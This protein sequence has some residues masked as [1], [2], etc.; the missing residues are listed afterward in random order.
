MYTEFLTGGIDSV[1]PANIYSS[2][3]TDS[4]K[5]CAEIND[6]DQLRHRAT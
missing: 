1:L 3:L 6:G 5:C 2:R 4:V